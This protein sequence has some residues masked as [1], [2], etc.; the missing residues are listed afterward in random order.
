VPVRYQGERIGVIDLE[1][2]SL[3][4]FNDQ[5]RDL[6][7]QWAASLAISFGNFLLI[8]KKVTAALRLANDTLESANDFTRVRPWFANVAEPAAAGLGAVA[9]GF[10]KLAPGTGYPIVPFAVWPP[11]AARLR[12]FGAP[13]TIH[14]S[15]VMWDV[16][17][18]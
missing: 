18:S 15:S 2:R 14:D 4:V 7:E 6:L 5:D 8:D 9:L 1:S 16:L 12:N 3:G 17:E 11:D 13:E 10:L